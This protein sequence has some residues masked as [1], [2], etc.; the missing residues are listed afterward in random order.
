MESHPDPID[1]ASEVTDEITQDAIDR[2]RRLAAPEQVRRE[3]GSWP[4]TDCQSCGDDIEEGRLEMGKLLC[5][6]C[7]T[8]KEKRAKGYV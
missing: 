1:R 2:Y 7:Q 4:H 3:D 6:R 5:F 8:I